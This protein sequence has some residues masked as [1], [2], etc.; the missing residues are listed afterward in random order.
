MID[1]PRIVVV[2]KPEPDIENADV[3]V[4]AV[5]ATVVVAKYRLPPAFLN[6]H[7]EIPI[8]AESASCGAVDDATVREA[9]LAVDVPTAKDDVVADIDPNG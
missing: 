8:P 4:V 6:V 3:D 7:C 2:P 1:S 5:P 9:K